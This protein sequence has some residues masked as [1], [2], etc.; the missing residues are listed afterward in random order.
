MSVSGI[1]RNL[2]AMSLLAG[3]YLK[4]GSDEVERKGVHVGVAA[5]ITA[6]V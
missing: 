4:Y 5:R 2:T 1:F 6:A 3:A